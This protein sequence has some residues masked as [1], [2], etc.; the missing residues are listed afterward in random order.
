MYFVRSQLRKTKQASKPNIEYLTTTI[1]K[2]LK[3]NKTIKIITQ[4]KV[5]FDDQ[6]KILETKLTIWAI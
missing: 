1:I 3:L 2:T 5:I 4:F 6:I